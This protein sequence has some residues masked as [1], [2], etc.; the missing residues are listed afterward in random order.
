MGF[1]PVS[2]LMGK[3]SGGG[4][5]SG[6]GDVTLMT[7]AQWDSLSTAAKRTYGLVAVQYANS[8]YDRGELVYGADYGYSSLLQSGTGQNTVTVSTTVTGDYKLIVIGMNSEAKS[9]S[10]NIGAE[11][12]GAALTAEVS[13]YNNYSTSGENNRNYRISVFGIHTT[14]GD[15]LKIT[16]TTNNKY[17]SFVFGIVDSS[18]WE[19]SKAMTTPDA[20]TTGENTVSGMVIY[21]TFAGGTGGT[22]ALEEY[23]AGRT[24][25]TNNPGISYKSSYIFWYS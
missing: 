18:Y 22:I 4:G 20:A 13:E 10:L 21:G 25:V 11:L 5:G 14:A 9:Y 7:R 16:L 15:S 19:F 6:G 2:Y 17:S 1:D 12:N 8:G 3:A 23:T 24:I